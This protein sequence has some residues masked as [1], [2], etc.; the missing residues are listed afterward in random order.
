MLKKLADTFILQV[1]VTLI[2]YTF[3][4][5]IL[6]LSLVPSGYLVVTAIGA[7]GH[8][9]TSGSGSEMFVSLTLISLVI[10]V[11][12]FLF[13]ITGLI[14]MGIIIR[15]LSLGIKPGSYGIATPTVFRWLIFSGIYTMAVTLILPVIPMTFFSLLFFRIIGAKIGKNCQIN[16]FM[17][18]DAY[19][20]EIGDD[21]IVGGQTDISCHIFENNKLILK[22]VTIGS[23]TMIGAHC[24]IS[25]G[26]TIGKN[27]VI[28]LNSYVRKDKDIPDN[29]RLT[30]VGAVKFRTAGKLEKK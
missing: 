3:Y 23:G 18:N 9:L 14:V 28:G 27:C 7:Y 13:F 5:L 10:G 30:S 25:P 24:Y 26:V 8:N 4:G 29:T 11:S 6:G 20:L 16:T 2:V 19:L 12:V 15:L 1:P 21:V 22:P 17:L